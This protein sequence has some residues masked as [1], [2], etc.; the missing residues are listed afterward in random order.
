MSAMFTCQNCHQEKPVDLRQ[1]GRQQY[2]GEAA[3]QR[4]RKATWQREKLAI[5]PAYS[6]RQ[7]ESHKQWCRDKPLHQYQRD[8]RERNPDYEVRNREMQRERNRKRREQATIRDS[9][10]KIVK[11]D[12]SSV[13]TIPAGTYE[14][15]PFIMDASKKVV[16]MDAWLVQLKTVS[17]VSHPNPP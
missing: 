12:A 13:T 3:C 14:L 15:R 1:K 4:A 7:K 9:A 10:E 8:Y 5:D 2:C 6:A 11:M 17:A 16:K